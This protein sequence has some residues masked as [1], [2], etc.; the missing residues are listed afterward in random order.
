[1][2]ISRSDLS[3]KKLT[4]SGKTDNDGDLCI[5]ASSMFDSEI[6]SY[7]DKGEAIKIIEHL[8]AVFDLK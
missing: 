5:E 2:T 6:Y 4:F 8:Q 7:I 3:I 1:M